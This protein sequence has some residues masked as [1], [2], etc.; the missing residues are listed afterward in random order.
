MIALTIGAF[1]LFAPGLLTKTQIQA[2]QVQ[3]E[4]QNGQVKLGQLVSVVYHYETAVPLQVGLYDYGTQAVAPLY[5]FVS[6]GN[7]SSACF[8]SCQ[9]GWAMQNSLTMTPVTTISPNTPTR[10]SI[11]SCTASGVPLTNPQLVGLG[12]YQLFIYST[13]NLGYAF[14]L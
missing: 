12:T 4:F 7:S 14:T 11:L 6:T 9:C 1:A 5:V 2:Q 3:N 8:H 13:N 10:L